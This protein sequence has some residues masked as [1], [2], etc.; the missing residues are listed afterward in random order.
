MVGRIR[1]D[2]RRVG[3]VRGLQHRRHPHQILTGPTADRQ[4]QD[5]VDNPRLESGQTETT[6]QTTRPENFI[7]AL[8]G[9]RD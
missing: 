3:Q 6:A 4:D 8:P 7:V 2:F 1:I 9:L 5:A